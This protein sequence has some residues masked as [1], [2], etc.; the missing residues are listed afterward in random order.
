M[1][2]MLCPPRP[3]ARHTTSPWETTQTARERLPLCPD[4][5][6]EA[7]MAR[8]GP[9]LLRAWNLMYRVYLEKAYA[10]PD[11]RRLWYGL[12]DALPGTG[13]IVAFDGGDIVGTVSVIPDSPL[14][15]PAE[16]LYENEVDELRDAGRRPVEVGSLG[17]CP[18]RERDSSIVT[19]L[20]DLLSLYARDVTGATDLIITVNPRHE[21]FYR[22]MLL[23]ERMGIEKSYD[24][25][26]KAPTVFMRLDL[27]KQRQVIRW[28]HGEGPL[29]IWHD[30]KHTMY[31]NFSSIAEEKRRIA[32]LDRESGPLDEDTVLRYF[33]EE[34]PL[35]QQAS[36]A[37]QYYLERCYPEIVWYALAD[38]VTAS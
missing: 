9:V 8:S 26:G 17:V 5:P 14:G 36:M 11:P 28:E 37:A 18:T 10:Q 33:V 25:V 35:L 6:Y 29:P 30:G 7:E 38:A 1:Y 15:Y 34:R 2:E 27:D 13:T 24:R 16:T 32:W 12:H 19:N 3:S 20:F 22:R 23:F 4:K 21:K 31:R